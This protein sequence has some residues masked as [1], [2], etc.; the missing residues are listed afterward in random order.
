MQERETPL[1][2]FAIDPG[3]SQSSYVI[4]LFTGD[5]RLLGTPMQLQS[6]FEGCPN[7]KVLQSLAGSPSCHFVCEDVVF[8]GENVHVG[9]SVFD[10]VRWC[11][12][13][14]QL[15]YTMGKT[16][17]FIPR[18]TVKACVV[19]N[20]RAKDP[21]VRQALIDRFGAVGKKKDP[22]PLFGISGHSWSAL[23]VAVTYSIR[24]RDSLRLN[25]HQTQC[26]GYTPSGTN[27]G[28]ASEGAGAA[29]LCGGAAERKFQQGTLI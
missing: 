6:V 25:K 10:T 29:K 12:R 19:N 14:E 7:E 2:V 24:Y 5:T 1:S 4:C 9:K 15:L 23:A 28:L 17:E 21:D 22:G 18:Q 11:G 20:T 8:Y 27:S 16:I 26:L 13:F 3:P